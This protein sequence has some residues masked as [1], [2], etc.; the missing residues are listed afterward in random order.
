MS[1][2]PMKKL[3]LILTI[4]SLTFYSYSQ[5]KKEKEKTN[6]AKGINTSALKFRCVGPAFTSGRISDIVVNPKKTSEY[7]VAVASGN[8]RNYL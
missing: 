2:N 1:T 6:Q 8:V 4:L 7:Y 3:L 5:D